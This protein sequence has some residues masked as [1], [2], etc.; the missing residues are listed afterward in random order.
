[1]WYCV[2]L[3]DYKSVCVWTWLNM[4]LWT[5]TRPYRFGLGIL[6][7]FPAGDVSPWIWSI[8]LQNDLPL[9]KLLG[10]IVCSAASWIA[11]H[12]APGPSV[13]DDMLESSSLAHRWL[14]CDQCDA[15]LLPQPQR[16][17][18]SSPSSKAMFLLKNGDFPGKSASDGCSNPACSGSFL[19]TCKDVNVTR[20]DGVHNH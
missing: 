6:E 9:S 20:C 16:D 19:W 8:W 4:F 17:G 10:C 7:S 12:L 2:I 11:D 5:P 14:C 13:A 18:R 1:M 3:C 15:W